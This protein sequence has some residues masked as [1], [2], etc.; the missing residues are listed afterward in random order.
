MS[1]VSLL[2]PNAT[3]CHSYDLIGLL[4][5]GPIQQVQG[6]PKRVYCRILF[7]EEIYNVQH[8]LTDMITKRDIMLKY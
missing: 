4:S 7:T 1:R 8:D 2:R 5:F 3:G 6:T